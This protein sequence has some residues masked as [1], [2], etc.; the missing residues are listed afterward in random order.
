MYSKPYTG[1]KNQKAPYETTHLRV[2]LPIKDQLETLSTVYK[3]AIKMGGLACAGDFV[4][5]LNKFVK[6]YEVFNEAPLPIVE[7]ISQA[8]YE[9]VLEELRRAKEIIN[10]LE[11]KADLSTYNCADAVKILQPAL[12][13]RANAGGAIKVAIRKALI[14]L[15]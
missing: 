2:P 9:N 4:S 13:L 7:A 12:K 3:F 6:K 14:L 15:K 1:G 5:Q 8:E 10:Q 11:N